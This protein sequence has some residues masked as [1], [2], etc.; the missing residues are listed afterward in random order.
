MRIGLILAAVLLLSVAMLWLVLR[1]RHN[2]DTDNRE[3]APQLSEQVKS[4]PPAHTHLDQKPLPGENIL[5]NYSTPNQSPQRDIEQVQE[6]V[7]NTMT[8]VKS[9][10]PREYATNEDLALFLQ[11]N[12][13]YKQAML[14]ANHPIINGRGQLIDRWDTPLV[15]HPL[16]RDQIEIFSAGPD[17]QPWNDDD[18]GRLPR[19]NDILSPKTT[20]E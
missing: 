17:G 16:G 15:V 5:Q 11:G 13:R 6:L 7:F 19:R 3:T 10:D 12:N 4:Q 1:P 18:I 14:P 2:G 9:R 20:T 8:L